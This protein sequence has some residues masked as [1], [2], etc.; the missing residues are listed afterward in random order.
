M[1]SSMSTHKF[2]S[3]SIKFI[4]KTIFIYSKTCLKRPLT[5]RQHKC[6]KDR[7]S[8]NAGQKYCRMLPLGAFCNTFDLHLAI[9]RDVKFPNELLALHVLNFLRDAVNKKV[10]HKLSELLLALH[11]I[12]LANASLRVEFYT[13]DN[14]S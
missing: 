14:Q 11:N 2:I 10:L 8:L 13:P 3:R 4:C 12:L 5:N 7:L 1:A 9:I 6:L